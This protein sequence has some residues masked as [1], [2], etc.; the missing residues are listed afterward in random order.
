MNYD[1][2]KGSRVTIRNL[3]EIKPTRDDI[4]DQEF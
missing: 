2:Q 1:H 4:E 3:F